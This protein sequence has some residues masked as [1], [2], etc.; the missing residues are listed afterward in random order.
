MP[1]SPVDPPADPPAPDLVE[2]L[3]EDYLD[4]VWQSGRD[5]SGTLLP[6]LP[7][8]L[9]AGGTDDLTRR[10]LARLRNIPRT[11]KD[12]HCRQVGELLRELWTS[13]SPWNAAALRLLDD[14]YTFVATGPRRHDDWAHDVLAVLDRSTADP[15]GLLRIDSD[16]TNP[17]RA[18]LPTYPFDRWT[19]GQ[20]HERLHPLT[21][22]AAVEAVTVMAEEWQS[23]PVP[24]RSRPDRDALLDYARTL[25]DR[26]GP[27]ARFWTNATVAATGQDPHFLDAGLAGTPCH[28][29]LTNASVG[30]FDFYEELGVIA[31]STDEVGVF[32]S[33]G[34]Y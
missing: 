21:P 24:V 14:P 13:R 4:A 19:A 23:E 31:V 9:R 17:V 15:R 2:D 10:A 12:E 3:L 1:Q 30:G 25:L 7:L 26:Y 28:R 16:R 8:A 6:E 29:F 18:E 27:A 33:I 34:A 32:W 22:A 5:G 11:S 20:I